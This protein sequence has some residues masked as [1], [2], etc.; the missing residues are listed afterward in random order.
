MRLLTPI[1]TIICFV[2]AFSATNSLYGVVVM[3]IAGLLG[4]LFKHNSYPAAPFLLAYV[5]SPMLEIH[6]RKALIIS[7]G[8]PFIFIQKPISLAFLLFLAATMLMP[9]F[10]PLWTKR[11]SK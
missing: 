10:K 7:H 8:S 5:L 9:L 3:L 11:F 4:Y 6:T 1:I 2:G